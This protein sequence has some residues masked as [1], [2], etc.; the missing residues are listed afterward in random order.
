[1]EIKEVTDKVTRTVKKNPL[2]IAGA[3]GGVAL[4]F[5]LS[6]KG[7][8]EVT[9]EEQEGLVA[10][11][12]AYASYPDAVTNAETIISSMTENLNYAMEGMREDFTEQLGAFDDRL[13]DLDEKRAEDREYVKESIDSA[14]ELFEQN[15]E[16][17]LESIHNSVGN[18]SSGS[19]Q[20]PSS[21]Q[22]VTNNTYVTSQEAQKPGDSV[23]TVD[24]PKLSASQAAER[25]HKTVQDRDAAF[26]QISK[27]E[28]R[29]ITANRITSGDVKQLGVL[30]TNHL[31]PQN[32]TKILAP[33]TQKSDKK[34]LLVAD[35][36]L[37]TK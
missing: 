27:A 33:A 26:A 12:G 24:L 14:K 28:R 20:P 19:I 35:K 11:N 31:N 5:V 10:Y 8:K 13:N 36:H 21:V 3:V 32:N 17:L 22:Y 25:M 4:F 37:I 29:E 18:T 6:K 23:N 7:T 2:L 9:Q 34:I 16:Q 15:N 30:T 1:M